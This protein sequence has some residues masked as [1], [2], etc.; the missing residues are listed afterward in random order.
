M[1][2]SEIKVLMCSRISFTETKEKTCTEDT[3]IVISS[4]TAQA[5]SK[6]DF[7]TCRCH[8]QLPT[9]REDLSI[10]VDDI[11]GEF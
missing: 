5:I 1:Y 11:R 2:S 8:P 10:C 4:G 7:C 3:C 6:K 9:F